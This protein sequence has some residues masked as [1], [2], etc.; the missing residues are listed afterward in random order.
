VQQA[1]GKQV[2]LARLETPALLAQLVQLV[3][4]KLAQLV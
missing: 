3:L 4:V 1:Q 2:Q